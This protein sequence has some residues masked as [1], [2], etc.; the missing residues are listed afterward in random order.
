MLL[1]GEKAI[2]QPDCYTK[3]TANLM[4]Q[5]TRMIALLYQR[6]SVF[7]HEVIAH[8]LSERK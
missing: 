4:R 3:D 7:P 8:N 6:I 2:Y 5:S 1:K